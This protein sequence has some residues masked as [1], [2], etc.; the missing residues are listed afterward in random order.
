MSD[1]PLVTVGIINCNCERYLE[2]CIGSFLDQTYPDMEILLIDDGST[3]GSAEILKRVERD[4]GNVRCISTT[5]I[6][7]AVPWDPGNHPGGEG[8]ILP[9]VCVGR[10]G[11]A[12]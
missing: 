11:R 3:D 5:E 4:H 12:R 10:Y 8:K 6:P 1:Q 7:G 2:K 9:V